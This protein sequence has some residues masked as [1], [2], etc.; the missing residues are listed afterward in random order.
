MI[1]IAAAN[2][3]AIQMNADTWHLSYKGNQ[4]A[5]ADAEGLRYVERFGISRRLPENG[6]IHP[7]AIRQVVIGWQSNDEAWH[8]GLVLAPEIADARG[9]RWCELATWPDPDQVVFEELAQRAG[10]GLAQVLGVPFRAVPPQPV[11][12]A[13]EVKPPPPLPALPLSFGLWSIEQDNPPASGQLLLI[14]SPR[15]T[16]GRIGRA[17]WYLFWALVYVGVSLLTLRSDLALPNAGTLLPNPELLPWLGLATAILLV[18]LTFFN[19]FRALTAIT[20]FVVD[21]IGQRIIAMN[22][23]RV[24][25]ERK[26]SEIRGVVVSEVVKR[27]RG[28]RTVEHGEINLHLGDKRYQYLLQ[29]GD[30]ISDAI[31]PESTETETGKRNASMEPLTRETISTSL[32][33]AGLYIAEALGGLPAYA[34]RRLR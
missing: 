34:D 21:P 32:Q 14:R 4:L 18:I 12:P 13:P 15:W 25:W 33:A 29:Q 9:S 28:D 5:D 7:A 26:A 23:K 20:H 3:L 10:E 8:L 11:A 2:N 19:L 17:F 1:E 22:G 27:K 6:L 30:A 16:R 31:S 24:R